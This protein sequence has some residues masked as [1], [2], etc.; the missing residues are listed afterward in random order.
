MTVTSRQAKKENAGLSDRE[1]LTS[2]KQHGANILTKRKRVS[3][4][5]QF[6]SNLGDPV[7]RILLAA[8]GINL[9]MLFQNTDWIETLGIAVAVFLAT[10]ISTLSEQGSAKAFEQLSAEASNVKCRA[11]RNGSVKEIP[12]SDVVVGDV[13]LLGAGEMIPADGRMIQG[14]LRSDQSAMTGEN[15]EVEKTP[16]DDATMTPSSRSALFRGC[17]VTSGGGEMEVTA[18]GDASFLGGISREIQEDTRESPLKRRLSKLAKQISVLG[19]VAA[20]LVA[21]A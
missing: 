15:A 11:R 10:L 21:L 17:S 2:R 12:I 7:I 13:I 4:W 9:L 18:V 20:F 14:S 16:S 6:L 1:V 5:R 8:L 19:Y 3:F